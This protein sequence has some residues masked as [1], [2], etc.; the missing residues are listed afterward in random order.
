MRREQ[1]A[2]K[3]REEEE[4][5]RVKAEERRQEAEKKRANQKATDDKRK[6]NLAGVFAV[7]E[8]DDDET[9]RERAVL[10]AKKRRTAPMPPP[11]RRP[12]QQALGDDE[13]VPGYRSQI[14][15]AFC[16]PSIAKAA[17]P[18]V[19]AAHAMRFMKLK[20]RFR[21]KEM[22]GPGRGRHDR[23]SSDSRP[24][25]VPRQRSYHSGGR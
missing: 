11:E 14:T 12:F 17:D 22:G 5:E 23:S 15:D 25:S 6:R 9:E 20:R 16:D 13:N 1:K 21:S 24:R 8:G 2:E 19:I 7:Q 18:G 4:R 3:K 10:A